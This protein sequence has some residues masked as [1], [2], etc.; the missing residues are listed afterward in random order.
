MLDGKLVDLDLK[1]DLSIHLVLKYSDLHAYQKIDLILNTYGTASLTINESYDVTLCEA[2]GR[3]LDLRNIKFS[4]GLV[5]CYGPTD[6]VTHCTKS[7]EQLL[8][9]SDNFKV[10]ITFDTVKVASLIYVLSNNSLFII[11]KDLQSKF[12]QGVIF[13]LNVGNAINFFVL[14]EMKLKRE[15]P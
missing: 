1:E 15:L 13:T 9:E 14:S 4:Q 2:L 8:F 12:E 6:M 11:N 3:D 10:P 5:V 7:Q